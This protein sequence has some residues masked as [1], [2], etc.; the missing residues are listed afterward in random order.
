MEKEVPNKDN[1]HSKAKI[2]NTLFQFIKNG[3][4][5]QFLEYI[6][7]FSQ[8]EID[9]NMRD[10]QGNYLIHFAIMMNSQKIIKILIEY[11]SRLDVLDAEGY[12]ILYYPIK[13][14]YTEVINILLSYNQK[15]LGFSLVNVRDARGSVPIFYAIRYGNIYA[16][17][18]LLT[19]GADPNYKNNDNM[20]ALH[21]AVL[22]KDLVMVKMIT[23]YIKNLDGRTSKGSTALHIACNFQLTDIVKI[24]LERGANQNIYESEYEFYPIFYAVVQNNVELTKM[25]IDF[26]SNPNNQDYIGNTAIHYAIINRHIEILD[27]FMQKYK[28]K[29]RS[30]DIYIEDINN[31]QNVDGNYIDPNIVNID[32]LT[33]VHLMLYDY[34]EEFDNYLSK[35]IPFS[36]LNYQDN[37]GNTILHIMAEKNLFEK[38]ESVLDVKKLNIYIRNNQN[39]TVIDM[40]QLRERERFIMM[41]VRSYYNYL[42]KYEY[43]W[44]LDWQNKC[45]QI[46]VPELDEKKCYQYIRN[47]ILEEKMSIPIKKNKKNISII[48]NELVQFST[49]TGTLLDVL[50]GFKYLTKKYEYVTSFFNFDQKYNPE[51]EKYNY[52][53]GIQENPN[54]FITNFEIRWIYQRIFFPPE[55]DSILSKTIRNGHYKYFIM[56]IG[57]ILSNGSHS[58]GLFY[59]IERK[60]LE[61]FEPHGSGYPNKFNYN[62]DLLD[63][64]LYRRLNIILTNLYGE[65]TK[66][67]YYAPKHYLPKIGF[68]ALENMEINVNKNIGD[69]NGFCTLWTIWYLDHRLKYIDM[70]PRSIVKKLI[71][72]VKMNRYSFRTIIRNYSK[73]ITELRDSYLSKINKNIND[74]LNNRLDKNDLKNLLIEILTD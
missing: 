6:S 18:E 36:D 73:K 63:D 10:E 14:N 2:V 17:Q 1:F 7:N 43:E 39:K 52:I 15:T 21:L 4:E 23:K 5:M 33:I 19:Y 46:N 49:F 69:P 71:N 26:G 30:S 62:P 40:V 50:V 44:L 65:H 13:L 28:I 32:G 25:L 60:V 42:K 38:F 48:Q 35:L 74:Y 37:H 20:T 31:N 8:E 56:P 34:I 54:Q 45:S 59:D 27:Y 68:Q 3:K 57:I 66:I 64:V 61:R 67:R 70:K 11:G 55:F 53:L 72:D 22:K 9:V 47:A 12:S 41:V 51:L 58:N 29:T 16:L 24:L